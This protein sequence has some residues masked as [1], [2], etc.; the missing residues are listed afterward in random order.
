MAKVKTEG[1]EETDEKNISISVHEFGLHNDTIN[2]IATLAFPDSEDR[3][4]EFR[5]SNISFVFR[6]NQHDYYNF[7]ETLFSEV[8]DEF[9]ESDNDNLLNSSSIDNFR[10]FLIAKMNGDK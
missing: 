10:D 7:I 5:T 2:P 9:E 8:Y 4:F 6:L 1:K 3:G